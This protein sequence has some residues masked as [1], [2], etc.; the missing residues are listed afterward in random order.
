MLPQAI[1]QDWHGSVPA[2]PSNVKS[3]PNGRQARLDRAYVTPSLHSAVVDCQAVDPPSYALGIS[4]HRPV[5]VTLEV[6]DRSPYRHPWRVDNRLFSDETARA[7]LRNRLSA[8]IGGHSWDALKQAWRDICTD[9]G[10]KLKHRYSGLVRATLQRIRIVERGEPTSLLMKTYANDLKLRLARLRTL[11]STT[12]SSYQARHLPSSHPEVL[13][14]VNSTRVG[15]MED[16]GNL[17]K[18]DIPRSPLTSL[19]GIAVVDSVCILG[20]SYRASGA[21]SESWEEEVKELKQ[22]ITRALEFN[23][24]Y[25]VRRYLLMGVFTDTYALKTTLR[26]LQLPEE[27]PARKLATYFLGVQS[28]LFLQTQPSGPKAINPTP[29][30]GHVIGIY[31]RIAQLNLDTPLL[32]C[33]NT[34]LAQELLVN[35][36]CE[37]KN[38]GFPWVLL[39]PSWLPGSIQD[40]VWRFGWSVLPTADRMY[41]WHYVR[42]EQC[43]HCKKHENNKHALITCRVAKIFW[44]LVDK[45]YHPL[46]IERPGLNTSA[47]TSNS[48]VVTLSFPS[49]FLTASLSSDA[50]FRSS[51]LSTRQRLATEREKPAALH[52]KRADLLGPRCAHFPGM[53]TK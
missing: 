21:T 2:I 34:E 26:V 5:V 12:A 39:T 22:Q 8:S 41:K 13:N 43:V 14:Y 32:E 46:G 51:S 27:H 23:F 6:K 10:K 11:T 38:P 53:M 33:R 15:R 52:E 18:Q 29:F 31:K 44:S 36:G 47:F 28:R 7:S 4:D 17:S 1:C 30:Y 25:Y 35:S 19:H 40:V 49:D 42:S 9:E 16:R 24:P 3:A 50:P 20:I 48:S 37:A 45:A